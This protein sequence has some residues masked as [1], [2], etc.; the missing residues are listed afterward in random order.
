MKYEIFGGNLPAVTVFLERG[1]SV[2]TQSGGMS[3][4]TGDIAMET[5]MQGGLFKGLGR[6]LSGESLFM[7]TYTAKSNGQSIT[8]ASSLPGNIVPLDVSGGKSYI[9]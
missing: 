4:M 8:I 3:W 2:Y 1:E 5:N 9:C 6:M 7:A